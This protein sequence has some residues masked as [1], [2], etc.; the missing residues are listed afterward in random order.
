MNL[1]GEEK[2]GSMQNK[3]VAVV[4]MNLMFEI[5]ACYPNRSLIIFLLLFC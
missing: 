5:P 3:V 2:G 1:A 4:E